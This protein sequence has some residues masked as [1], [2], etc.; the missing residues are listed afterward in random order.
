MVP[1]RQN[2]ISAVDVQERS[3]GLGNRRGIEERGVFGVLEL[4]GVRLEAV[5]RFELWANDPNAA[6]SAVDL[7]QERLLSEI[8]L[9]PAPQQPVDLFAEGFLRLEAK[10]AP[11]A[12]LTEP[13]VW[14]RTADYSVLYEHRFADAD[15]AQSLIA[16]IPI[17]SDLERPF[18]PNRETTVVTD[19]MVRWDNEAAPPLVVRG[20]RTLARLGVLDFQAAAMPTGQVT[21]TR[22]F[23]GA[24]G[25]PAVAT[26]IEN[27]LDVISD[28]VN[29]Q[30]H[31]TFST[32]SLNAFLT[33][34]TSVGTIDLGDWDNDSVIDTY[35]SRVLSFGRTYSDL[36]IDAADATQISSAALPFSDA[37]RGSVL[38][39]T[40]G[41]GFDVGDYRIVDVDGAGIATLNRS[42]GSTASTNGEG[43]IDRPLILPNPTDQIEIAYQSAAFDQV[44]VL[45][46]RATPT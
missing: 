28:P 7:V 1:L 35:E 44:G 9:P 12:E 13:G 2:T 15:D 33:A 36:A 45:Y 24:V 23:D 31:T 30:N 29:P 5:F 40:G 4:K 14:R 25:P 27:F 41:V 8:P 6:N 38:E 22:T 3:V 26:S 21:M 11:P 39:V 19:E 34:F 20:R 10:E 16:R 18:S 43:K 37:E 42:C 32:A 17:H 46:L